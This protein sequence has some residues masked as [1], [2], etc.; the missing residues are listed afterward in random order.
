MIKDLKNTDWRRRL[1][2]GDNLS[3]HVMHEDKHE[4]CIIFV[5]LYFTEFLYDK[6]KGILFLFSRMTHEFSHE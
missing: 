4:F 1:N 3:I 2:C 5:F 6:D